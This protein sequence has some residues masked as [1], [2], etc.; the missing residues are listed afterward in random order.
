[1]KKIRAGI[2]GATGYTGEEIVR[3]LSKHPQ[4]D[5]TYV[6]GKEDRDIKIQ[7]IFPYL[8]GTLDLEC[9]PFQFDEAVEKCDFVFLS[10]PHTV[11]MQYAPQF[12]KAK[13][14]VIDVSADF[15]L[16]DTA[17]YEKFYKVQ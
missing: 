7:Q 12:I 1:M 11:S 16:K 5:V 9:K 2:I 8:E 10:L 13:K 3:I 15:R 6:S 14:R 17:V 4:V